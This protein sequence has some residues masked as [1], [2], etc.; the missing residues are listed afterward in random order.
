MIAARELCKRFGDHL[1]LDSVM[2]TISP[3][4]RVALLGLN[5]AGK[6]TFMRCLLGLLPFEGDLAVAGHEVRGDG[7]L[8]RASLGMCPNAPR[9]SSEPCLRYWSSSAAS[10]GSRKRT[11]PARWPCWA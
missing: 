4:E 7:L 10:A 8:A 2:L 11:W 5:R 1:V 3:G 9:T 6:T